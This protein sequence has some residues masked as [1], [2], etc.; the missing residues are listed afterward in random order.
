MAS[1]PE[2]A[3]VL[4]NLRN[5]PCLDRMDKDLNQTVENEFFHRVAAQGAPA[6]AGQAWKQ[7]KSAV[8]NF[9]PSLNFR[10]STV[11]AS[12]FAD[13]I[14]FSLPVKIP[15]I[16]PTLDVSAHGLS[17]GSLDRASQAKLDQEELDQEELDRVRLESVIDE[18]ALAAQITLI[19][20]VWVAEVT[21]DLEV[22]LPN[23]AEMMDRLGLPQHFEQI[24][25]GGCCVEIRYQRAALPAGVELHVPSSLDGID[26]DQFRP[27]ADCAA[28]CGTTEPLTAGLGGGFPEAVHKGCAVA[29]FEIKLLP[30]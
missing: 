11:P 9:L 18:A 26:N 24:K 27:V 30:P 1:T 5:E 7:A 12:R 8:W 14:R 17:L 20:V 3:Q 2:T 22:T 16:F 6:D 19:N 13:L 10:R 4:Q 29:P 15:Y 21:P 25:S 28:P 23:L